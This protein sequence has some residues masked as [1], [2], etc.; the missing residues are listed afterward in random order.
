ME[1]EFDVII[2]TY[3]RPAKVRDLCANI[4]MLTPL[5][6]RLIV[7]DSSDEINQQLKQDTR[8]TYLQSSIKSQPYQRY[9]GTLVSNADVLVF[10]DDDLTIVNNDLFK[11]VLDAFKQPNVVG[12]GVGIEYHNIINQQHVKATKKSL[13]A[14]TSLFYPKPKPGAIGRFGQTTKLP[15][16]VLEVD[17]LPGPNMCFKSSIIKHLFNETLFELFEKKI[18][19]GEDKAISMKAS[20][21][22]TMLY[23]GNK[24]YLHHPAEESSYFDNYENFLAKVYYSRLWLAGQY[25]KEISIFHLSVLKILYIIK[26]LFSIRSRKMYI[27]FKLFLSWINKYG[28]HQQKLTQN[29]Y[30]HQALNDAKNTQFI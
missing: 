22:G 27:A 3:N 24:K 13:S 17:Y 6:G 7:V 29:Q 15:N 12:V 26:V 30:Y 9:L 20:C 21:Y 1:N 11:D 23:L 25:P 4:L 5:P 14:I 10:F 16:E 18:A 8:I 2:T 19:M 28:L